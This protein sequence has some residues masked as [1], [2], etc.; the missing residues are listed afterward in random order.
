MPAALEAPAPVRDT[1]PK[2]IQGAQKPDL[3]LIPPVAL[4]YMATAMEDGAA[5]Y[6]PFNWREDPV[7]FRTYIAA[8]MRHLGN[9]LDGEDRCDDSDVLQLASVM[10]SC[11]ILIDAQACGTL[12]DNRPPTGRSGQVQNEIKAWKAARATTTTK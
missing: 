1:N 9:V 7:S 11:A 10:A 6:G 12:I 4:A 8:C 3:S 5:K 2:T